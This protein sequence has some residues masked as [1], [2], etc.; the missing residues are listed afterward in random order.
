MIL[1]CGE[2]RWRGGAGK[3]AHPRPLLARN[4]RSMDC[5]AA[6]PSAPAPPSHPFR[7]LTNDIAL[8]LFALL[9]PS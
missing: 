3:E 6:T 8:T 9:T 5:P 7:S 4:A 2:Y 1:K